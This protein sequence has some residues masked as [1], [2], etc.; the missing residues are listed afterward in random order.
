MYG[1]VD[2]GWDFLYLFVRDLNADGRESL[3]M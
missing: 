2:A 3:K 1:C